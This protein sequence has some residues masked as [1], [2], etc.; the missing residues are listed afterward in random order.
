M[1]GQGRERGVA[2]PNYTDGQATAW[3][4]GPSHRDPQ[5]EVW[6]WPQSHHTQG[7]G[8]SSSHPH[9][10]GLLRGQ[11]MD[12]SRET[13]EAAAGECAVFSESCKGDGSSQGGHWPCI[14]LF[15]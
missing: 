7:D 12:S 3:T 4:M 5:R 6:R 14:Q 11:G 10:R 1:R 15:S 8:V 2:S 9:D 13:V